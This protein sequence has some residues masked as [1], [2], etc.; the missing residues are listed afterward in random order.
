M[1]QKQAVQVRYQLRIWDTLPS[2]PGIGIAWEGSPG[3]LPVFNTWKTDPQ[4]GV[5]VVEGKPTMTRNNILSLV[6]QLSMVSLLSPLYRRRKLR[7]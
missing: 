3:F 1:F 4:Q 6:I 7:P 2:H 5:E